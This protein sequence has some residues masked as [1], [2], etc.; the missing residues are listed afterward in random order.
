[1]YLYIF[2]LVFVDFHICPAVPASSRH[3][4]S[5]FFLISF[6]EHKLSLHTTAP[7]VKKTFWFGGMCILIQLGKTHSLL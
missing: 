3:T 5:A 2:V 7:D 4:Y 1:M 6:S